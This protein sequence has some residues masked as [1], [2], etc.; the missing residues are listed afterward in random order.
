[1]D[2]DSGQGSPQ[3]GQGVEAQK[4]IATADEEGA[5]GRVTDSSDPVDLGVNGTIISDVSMGEASLEAS[6]LPKQKDANQDDG[7]DIVEGEED[8]VIY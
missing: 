1:M 2:R 7:G 8:T 3:R 5:N 4:A 6:E